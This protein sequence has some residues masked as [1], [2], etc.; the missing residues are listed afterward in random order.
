MKRVK[1]ESKMFYLTF[2]FKS[3][4]QDYGINFVK[5][6]KKSIYIYIYI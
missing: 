6:Y 4:V 5:A 2:V 1:P 3:N